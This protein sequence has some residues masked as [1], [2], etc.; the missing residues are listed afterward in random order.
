MFIPVIRIRIGRRANHPSFVPQRLEVWQNLARGLVAAT[1]VTALSS[2][3]PTGTQSGGGG[4]LKSSPIRTFTFHNPR[5]VFFEYREPQKLPFK[6][7]DGKDQFHV[8]FIQARSASSRAL[9]G[10]TQDSRSPANLTYD[11]DIDGKVRGGDRDW[12]KNNAIWGFSN[13]NEVL[14]GSATLS[15][16]VNDAFQTV[17]DERK[18]KIAKIRWDKAAAKRHF[19]IGFSLYQSGDFKASAMAFVEGL[20]RYPFSSAAHYYLAENLQRLQWSRLAVRH[21]DLAKWLEPES[22][23]A[24]LAT[25]AL[26]NPFV[27]NNRLKD[28]VVQTIIDTCIVGYSITD[29]LNRHKACGF[30]SGRDQFQSDL[31]VLGASGDQ[32]K[33]IVEAYDQDVR[34]YDWRSQCDDFRE[35]SLEETTVL[36]FPF[37]ILLSDGQCPMSLLYKREYVT[38][39]YRK[40]RKDENEKKICSEYDF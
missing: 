13:L 35:G 18:Q 7:L 14:P 20:T 38:C 12:V 27:E 15:D 36:S 8:G 23:E 30:P 5:P 4:F 24:L 16:E 2:C 9:S 31:R 21:Y 17:G 10:I 40:F 34:I 22:K 28:F 29:R 25:A 19:R 26:T 3:G 33:R 11:K 37:G 6:S 32:E 1:V 39:P